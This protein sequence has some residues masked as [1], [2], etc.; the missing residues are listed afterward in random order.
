MS[1]AEIIRSLKEA[2]NAKQTPAAYDSSAVVT[3]IEG[4]ATAWVKIAGSD[5]ETPV[6]LTIDAKAGDTVQVR[7][8][9]GSAWLTGNQSAPPTDNTK[10]Q[11]AIVKAQ[12]AGGTAYK[13]ITADDKNGIKVHAESSQLNYAQI[14]SNGMGIYQGVDGK[15]TEVASFKASG[16]RIGQS[17]NANINVKPD[18]VIMDGPDGNPAM[19]MQFSE[20]HADDGTIAYGVAITD[21]NEKSYISITP[22]SDDD[23]LTFNDLLEYRAE[24]DGYSWVTGDSGLA[25]M[26]LGGQ[27]FQIRYVNQGAPALSIDQNSN[28]EVYAGRPVVYEQQTVTVTYTAGTVGT[29]G[30][31]VALGSTS[32]TGYTFVGAVILDHPNAD[33]FSAVISRTDSAQRAYLSAYR[34]TTGAVSGAEVKVR[35]IWVNN[36]IIGAVE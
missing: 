8:G 24:M 33:K 6:K 9:G 35:M 20:M 26:F 29:R 32:K 31:N 13:Y 23:Y 17:G 30:A 15:A 19:V 3:R 27:S 10:A 2:M 11:E 5:T 7:V 16:A 36:K 21:E 25:G 12:E 28:I 34:A 1:N 18:Q 4:N 14:D 22:S